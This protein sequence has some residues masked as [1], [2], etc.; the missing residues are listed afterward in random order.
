MAVAALAML[1]AVA[2]G[3]AL[4]TVDPNDYK[5]QLVQLVK[6]RTGRTLTLG[7]PIRLT[8]FPS[9]G[10]AVD[11]VALSGPGGEGSFASVSNARASVKLLPLLTRQVVVDELRLSGLNAELVK[12]Q[13]GRTNFDDLLAPQGKE[14]RPE[15]KPSAPPA[16]AQQALTLDVG[17]VSLKDAN[18]RWRDESTGTD[19]RIGALDMR[20]D[21]IAS[22]VP[23][24]IAVSASIDGAQPRLALTLSANAGY[25]V[26]FAK[27]SLALSALDVKLS[28]NVPGAAGLDA[29]LK[30]DVAV[31][32]AADRVALADFTL[33]ATSKDGL[34]A[35]LAVPSLE[36]SP[37]RAQSKAIEGTLH[38]DRADRK[39]DAKLVVDAATLQDK[40]V[41][42][43]RLAVD[44][45]MQQGTLGVRGTL[46]GAAHVD[47][48]AQRISTP[49]IAG[50]FDVTGPALPPGGVKLAVDGSAEANWG[51]QTAATQLDARLDDSHIQAGAKVT[52]FAPL[53]VSFDVQADRLDVDRYFPPKPRTTPSAAASPAPAGAP[54]PVAAA[55]AEQPIDL[56]PLKGLNASGNIRVGALKVARVEASSVAATLKAAGGRLDVNPLSANLYQ[57]ALTGSASVDANDNGYALRTQVTNVAIGPL[58]RDLAERDVLE[59]RG[60]VSLDVRVHGT[61]P[62]ALKR[63]LAGSTALALRDGAVKGV[64]LADVLRRA[65]A[66]L[67]SRSA[68]E[69]LARGGARTDFTE[70]TATFA[71]RDGVAR[72]DDLAAKSPLLRVGGEGAIDIGASTVDYLV[73]ATVVDTSGGQGG[74]ELEQLRG[75]TIPVRLVGPFDRVAYK[76]DIASVAADVAKQEV[77]RRLEEKLGAKPGAG[78]AVGDALRGLFGGKR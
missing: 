39:L 47:L 31:D 43:P 36:L 19:V 49:K 3:V 8:F 63:S 76:V 33:R 42:F 10:A 55:A 48:A 32:A 27:R 5:P 59:G 35:N 41:T 57:G 1:I 71:I 6:E 46:G 25:R 29:L 38:I 60:N 4:A 68:A 73:R 2:I 65:K 69:D 70:L 72:N 75:I 64:N 54:P 52:R 61:T 67:G 62:S 58:V 74:R 56:S 37:E 78:G 26:D 15:E 40:A 77:T 12:Y 51:K 18:V 23:G 50:N 16:G 14:P 21:R 20:T 13:D 22:G 34:A 7:G 44:L 17:G 11:R 24:R 45:V 66:A 30:G 9:V 53:A 28:G